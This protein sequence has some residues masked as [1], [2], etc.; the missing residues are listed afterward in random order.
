MTVTPPFSY[1]WCYSGQFVTWFK[2][3]RRSRCG[4]YKAPKSVLES[5]FPEQKKTVRWPDCEKKYFRLIWLEKPTIFFWFT[6]DRTEIISNHSTQNKK[7]RRTVGTIFFRE[8]LLTI[9]ITSLF[10]FTIIFFISSLLVHFNKLKLATY[11]AAL[12]ASIN[13]LWAAQKWAFGKHRR[14]FFWYAQKKLHLATV[15]WIFLN[16]F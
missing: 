12:R 15:F 10:Y 4:C 11:L 5:P 7:F 16:S 14:L 6:V 13:A 9:V 2:I 8:I 3:S 1:P